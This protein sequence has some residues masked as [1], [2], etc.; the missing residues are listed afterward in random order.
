MGE[1]AAWVEQKD[2]TQQGWVLGNRRSTRNK[3]AS[4]WGGGRGSL[5]ESLKQGREMALFAVQ[6]H[7]RISSR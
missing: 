3:G 1:G 4:D 5:L 2:V 7:V 6:G